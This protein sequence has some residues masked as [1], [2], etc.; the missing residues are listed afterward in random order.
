MSANQDV[1]DLV[2]Q[3]AEVEGRNDADGLEGLLAA[4]FVAV[5][6]RGFVLSS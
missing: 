6:P 2:R 3:W 5:G 1:L 4:N